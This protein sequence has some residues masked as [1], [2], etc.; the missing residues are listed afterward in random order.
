HGEHDFYRAFA[1]IQNN[2][3]PH[4][5]IGHNSNGFDMPFIMR[6]L[7]RLGSTM[8]EEF[9]RIANG[10]Q[11]TYGEMFKYNVLRNKNITLAQGEDAIEYTYIKFDRT[12]F[13]DSMTIFQREFIG[14]QSSL[15][16]M[17]DT[18][19][20]PSKIGL[21]YRRIDEIV[22]LAIEMAKVQDEITKLN[23]ESI[24][25]HNKIEELNSR[26]DK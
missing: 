26:Q 2:I 16:Y 24:D 20:I 8:M 1:K 25:Y 13:W 9:Y 15:N 17:L 5:I 23:V 18:L 6:R 3:K 14:R 4:M 21:S 10:K 12:L 11:M 7:E 19:E 22:L